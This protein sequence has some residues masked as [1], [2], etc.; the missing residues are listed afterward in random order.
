MLGRVLQRVFARAPRPAPSREADASAAAL[1]DRGNAVT[2]IRITLR[3]VKAPAR[4]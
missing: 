1:V 2:E 4:R 3:A